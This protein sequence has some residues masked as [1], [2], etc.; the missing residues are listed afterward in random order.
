MFIVTPSLHVLKI[1]HAWKV[2]R[3]AS[4][5]FV[6]T[7]TADPPVKEVYLFLGNSVSL[8]KTEFPDVTLIII[9]RQP[10]LFS[11]LK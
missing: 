9:S 11:D 3:T 6:E 8:K 5:V 2:G 1:P 7:T 4:T 10:T